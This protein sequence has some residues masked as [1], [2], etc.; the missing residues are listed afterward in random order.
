MS[1]NLSYPYHSPDWYEMYNKISDWLMS[2]GLW[3]QPHYFYTKF[4]RFDSSSWITTRHDAYVFVMKEF[5]EF[6]MREMLEQFNLSFM[7]FIDSF[8]RL[9]VAFYERTKQKSIAEINTERNR[10]DLKQ[11]KTE[12]KTQN[13]QIWRGCNFGQDFLHLV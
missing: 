6:Q 4:D 2:R 8:Q 7:I 3:F 12:T 9:R 11:N 5:H 10:T 13:F 1:A